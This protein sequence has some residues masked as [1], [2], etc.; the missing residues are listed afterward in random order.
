MVKALKR[1]IKSICPV[2]RVNYGQAQTFQY[3]ELLPWNGMIAGDLQRSSRT[4]A[5]CGQA[6]AEFAG[7]E[8]HLVSDKVRSPKSDRYVLP[9]LC[10]S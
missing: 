8:G 6:I 2:V 9:S 4:T 10:L 5:L 7:C 1:K 3:W